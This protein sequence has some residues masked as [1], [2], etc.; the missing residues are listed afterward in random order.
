[1]FTNYASTH[2]FICLFMFVLT[3]FEPTSLRMLP[4]NANYSV[5]PSLLQYFYTGLLPRCHRT[6]SNTVCILSD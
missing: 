1:M 4:S 3:E 2:H 5:V 6:D